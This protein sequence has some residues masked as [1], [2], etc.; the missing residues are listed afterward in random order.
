MPPAIPVG[1]SITKKCV[2]GSSF[3]IDSAVSPGLG[4]FHQRTT[5]GSQR[6]RWT[7]STSARVP[8]RSVNR[9]PARGANCSHIGQGVHLPAAVVAD[10]RGR[11]SNT[12][13]FR[14]VTSTAGR[15]GGVAKFFID[16]AIDTD[17]GWC[18]E[19]VRRRHQPFWP[20]PER[21]AAA[22]KPSATGFQCDLMRLEIAVLRSCPGRRIWRPVRRAA[23]P[24]D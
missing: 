20:E 10:A 8:W 6:T 13:S 21:Y 17:P 12:P 19:L 5:V 11:R 23:F 1:V 15:G 4:A 7:A 22:V 24:P 2:F 18:T 16:G 14:C 9:S 3:M